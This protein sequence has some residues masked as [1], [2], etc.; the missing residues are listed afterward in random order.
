M[1]KILNI[2]EINDMKIESAHS[3]N[4]GLM[5]MFNMLAGYCGYDG[6]KVSTE[7]GE[8]YLL[9]DNGASCCEQ[10]GYFSTEDDVKTF[11]GAELFDIELTDTS[12]KTEAIEEIEYLDGGGVQFVTFKTNK[13]N[14]QLAVYNAHN[15]YYGHGIYLFKNGECLLNSS[16]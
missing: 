15:G 1:N 14:F 12:L 16:L 8:I 6:Y 11:I 4:L 5:G 7:E 3:G 13:G 10:W 2:E 9:I